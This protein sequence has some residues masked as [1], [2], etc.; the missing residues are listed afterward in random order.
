[1]RNRIRF[2]VQAK[3]TLSFV[4]IIL[5]MIATGGMSYWKTS[6]MEQKSDEIVHDAMV[7][8][9]A[10]RDLHT[11]LVQLETGVRGYILTEKEEY[12]EPYFIGTAELVKDLAQIRSY[13]ENHPVMKDLIENKAYPQIKLLQEYFDSQV[14][15]VKRGK[16]QEA[17]DKLGNGKRAM[18]E[19]NKINQQILKNVSNIVDAASAQ[20]TEAADQA[21]LTIIAGAASALVIAVVFALL[22]IKGIV[23]PI[24]RISR[25]MGEI[26]DGEGDLTKTIEVG[27]KDELAD[28]AASF[29]RMTSSLR[30]LI[31]QVGQNAEMVMA[32]AEELTASIE[33]NGKASEQIA[34]GI[35]EAAHDA[36]K[37]V[38]HI[39]GNAAALTQ[40]AGGLSEIAAGA[41][42]VSGYAERTSAIAQAGSER[43]GK[44][45]A[46]MD[47]INKT[48]HDLADHINELGKD[49][50]E[51]EKIVEAI[52][53]I[54]AQTNLLALNAAIEAARAGEHGRGFAVVAGEVRKLAEQSAESSRQ[55]TELIVD[56]QNEIKRAVQSMKQSADEVQEGIRFV[57]QVGESFGQIQTAVD[58]VTGRIMQ[59][60]D[61]SRDVTSG[62]DQL[63]ASFS[64]MI[65]VVEHSAAGAQAASN[66]SE[67]QLASVEE[68]TASAALLAKMSEQLQQMIARFNV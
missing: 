19:F 64:E 32:S 24:R 8:G 18:D 26:A 68:I 39:K 66:A 14:D 61:T 47:S 20:T 41:T 37:Q 17:L 5:V 11:D 42:E 9:E 59:V 44:A 23:R 49:S 62:T 48:V 67:V 51:I 58:E 63:S 33:Q 50:E 22:L 4:I 46:Q 52:T 25:Q 40:M 2:T 15:L 54:A 56:I 12:L 60:R 1:M 65:A 6:L 55:I 35:Q 57:H 10:A 30:E 43:I 13:E 38:I 21:K 31:R 3:I 53:G 7:I 16:K 36:E 34:F 29:N 27:T 45:I 28:L